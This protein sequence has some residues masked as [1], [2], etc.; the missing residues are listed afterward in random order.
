MPHV[1]T[2]I[3]LFAVWLATGVAPAQ[4]YSAGSI[5]VSKVW[6]RE[7]PAGAKVAAGFMTITNTGREPDTLIGGSIAVAEKFEVHEMTMERGIM[8]MRRL[9]P[10]LVVKPGETV[11]L[12][13]GSFHLMFIDLRQAPKRGAPVKGTLI[14]EK[15]GRIEVE[16]MVAPIGARELGDG[17]QPG[18][19]DSGR[20][21]AGSHGHH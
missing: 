5:K 17:A 2:V 3:L 16:Y 10:G 11:T 6:T 13:P 1:R 14:F 18:G 19:K 12:K 7:V 20:P 15:A 8:R 21:K 4:D 9:A